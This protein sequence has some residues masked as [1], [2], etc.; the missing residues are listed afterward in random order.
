MCVVL[1]S[2][3]CITNKKSKTLAQV[4]NTVVR[5]NALGV[6]PRLDDLCMH[7]C[8]TSCPSAAL[9]APLQH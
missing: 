6:F 8:S 1:T 7:L 9:V 3:M 5:S 2:L 4:H